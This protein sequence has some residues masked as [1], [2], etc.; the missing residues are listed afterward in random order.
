M[1]ATWP[2]SDRPF[3][4]EAMLLCCAGPHWECTE[5]DVSTSP[6]PDRLNM[7]DMRP[8][9]ELDWLD[10]LGVRLGSL[11]LPGPVRGTE[12]RGCWEEPL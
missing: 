11:R 2:V 3:G 5:G 12:G 9:T 6:K 8:T 10:W 1:T 4:L 7:L